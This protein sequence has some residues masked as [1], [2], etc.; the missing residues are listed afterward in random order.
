M[1]DQQTFGLLELRMLDDFVAMRVVAL[2]AFRTETVPL[3]TRSVANL[4]LGDAPLFCEEP[5]KMT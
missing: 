4:L 5:G 2:L 1:H 3:T